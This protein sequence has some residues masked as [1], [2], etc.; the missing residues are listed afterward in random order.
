MEINECNAWH[1]AIAMQ[2]EESAHF[3]AAVMCTV[4]TAD[5]MGQENDCTSID[6]LMEALNFEIK[7][8]SGSVAMSREEAI[9]RLEPLISLLEEGVLDDIH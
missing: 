5:S 9:E 3:V 4:A 8:E 7:E 6:M 1:Y 2:S